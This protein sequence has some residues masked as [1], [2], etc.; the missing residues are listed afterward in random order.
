ML[1]AQ[2]LL[3][4]STLAQ[5]PSSGQVQ[6]PLDEYTRLVEITRQPVTVK[7]PVPESYALGNAVM[8][9][10][11]S[12]EAPRAVATVTVQLTIDVLE[13]QWVQVPVL[14]A[15]TPGKP[16]SMPRSTR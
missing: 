2:M 5:E 16:G 7:R 13:D 10:D 3:A 11:V 4:S 15:G 12:G 14:P 1:T 9:V 8:T 6:L